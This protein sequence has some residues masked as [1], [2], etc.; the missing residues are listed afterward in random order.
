MIDEQ[1]NKPEVNDLVAIGK[2]LEM[3]VWTIQ[4]I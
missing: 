4:S 2:S 1:K 3:S